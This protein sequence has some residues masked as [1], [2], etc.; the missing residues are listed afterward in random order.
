VT[1]SP[2]IIKMAL[3]LLTVIAVLVLLLSAWL[4]YLQPDG[5]GGYLTGTMAVLQLVISRV[6]E[7]IRASKDTE[8]QQPSTEN[9]E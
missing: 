8:I 2:D 4:V 9:G 1:A 7:A 5:V 6:G 3:R